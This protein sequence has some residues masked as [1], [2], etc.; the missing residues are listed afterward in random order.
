MSRI[1]KFVEDLAKA[2][3]TPKE[4]KTLVD[5]AFEVNS[6]SQSKNLRISAL[7]KSEKDSSDKRSTNERGR[8]VPLTLLRL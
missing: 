7:V 2:R 1:H 4:N 6:I 8:S 5:T 3:T